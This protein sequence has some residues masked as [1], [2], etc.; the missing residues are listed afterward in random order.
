MGKDRTDYNDTP[1]PMHL[2]GMLKMETHIK[3]LKR[4]GIKHLQASWT[5][6]GSP[7]P[8]LSLASW[9]MEEKGTLLDF[10]HDWL[11]ENLGD[12]VYVAQKQFSQAF[13]HF[14]FHIDTLYYGSQNFGPMAP[15]FLQSTGYQASMIGFPYD[16]MERW[17]GVYLV[18]IFAK[19][20]KQLCDEWRVGLHM[21]LPH[22]GNS[23]ELDDVIFW[24]KV[25]QLLLAD[26]RVGYESSNHYFYTLQDLK[27]KIINL[28][29][30]EEICRE[31]C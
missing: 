1:I 25:I 20:T 12:V 5:L 8:N 18:T 3:N 26:S 6:G 11:G 22:E 10:L 16:D 21:L 28:N 13:S 31:S 2:V 30:C 14:P 7:S 19:E 24:A 4:Q 23:K 15:F 17:R 29:Y 9:L 27:E